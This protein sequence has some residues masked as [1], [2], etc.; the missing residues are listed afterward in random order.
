MGR[1]LAIFV[2]TSLAFG[3]EGAPGDLLPPLRA[4]G[5]DAVPGDRAA[6][7]GA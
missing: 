6:E 1:A 5:P 7:G 3:G 4:V 2:V